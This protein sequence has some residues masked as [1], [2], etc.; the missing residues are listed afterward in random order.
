MTEELIGRLSMIRGLASLP[1][2]SVMAFKD[3]L[4]AGN[5]EDLGR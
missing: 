3:L 2:I 4:H 5:R 1:C